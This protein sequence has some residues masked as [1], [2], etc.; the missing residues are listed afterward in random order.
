[1]LTHEKKFLAALIDIAVVLLLTLIVYIFVPKMD[2]ANSF[3]F[4]LMYAI[5]AFLYFFIYLMISKDT[6][7]GLRIMDLKIVNKDWSK[8]T[9][10]SIVI[11]SASYGLLVMYLL[12]FLYIF[13]NK[14]EITL[15]D[16]LSD[17]FIA[18]VGD[19]YKVNKK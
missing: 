6:T 13:I 15:F 9:R 1:M 12:N 16:E 11:R 5:V 18:P 10:K 7:L 19:A 14:S 4:A 3:L 17:T 8:P 2:Y